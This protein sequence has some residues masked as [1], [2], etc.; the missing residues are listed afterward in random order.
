MELQYMGKTLLFTRDSWA[1]WK[2]IHFACHSTLGLYVSSTQW[3]ACGLCCVLRKCVGI[4]YNP[5]GWMSV[6]VYVGLQYM[7][8]CF[9]CIYMFWN[10]L[11]FACLVLLKGQE[12]Q[13]IDSLSFSLSLTLSI[14]LT[15]SLSLSALSP[16]S[17]SGLQY[18][19]WDR[20]WAKHFSK[21]SEEAQCSA[22]CSLAS[23]HSWQQRNTFNS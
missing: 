6:C 11:C 13:S 16:C 20:R 19:D 22:L 9:Y 15:H 23:S 18:P 10:S 21:L 3:H 12:D 8:V 17:P 4:L 7:R 14:S 2:R 5:Y 1:W